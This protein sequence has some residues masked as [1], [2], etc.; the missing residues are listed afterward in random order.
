M[1]QHI[2]TKGIILARTNF[3]EADRII[4]VLTSSQEKI[5]LLAKGVRKIKS[6]NAGG[7]ELFS[8]ND[9]TYMSGRSDLG[10]LLTTRLNENFGS[11]VK[12]IDRTMYAYQVLKMF[13]K[14][15]EDS[16][17]NGYFELLRTALSAINKPN[18]E[19]A[20]IQLWLT[21]H[22]LTLTGHSPNLNTDKNGNNLIASDDYS[23]ALDEMTFVQN[24]S[25]SYKADH[26]KLLRLARDS[27]EP[28]QLQRI[29]HIDHLL[30]DLVNLT[31]LM[32]Q[33]HVRVG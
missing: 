27:N 33:Q 19:I 23:I 3:G 11:I 25:G 7:I 2:V 4:T 12:D 6:K 10:T 24:K 17:D 16:L 5:R 28:S 30:A 1:K 21:M 8:V 20:Y 9:V 29:K 32:L 18:L 22:I 26:I 15:T 14:I 13:N 31:K